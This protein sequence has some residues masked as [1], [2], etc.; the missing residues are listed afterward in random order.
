MPSLPLASLCQAHLHCQARV[1][2]L[3]I[4]KFIILACA[5]HECIVE[6]ME[7]RLLILSRSP[8]MAECLCEV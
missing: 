6:V 7:L 4:T 2:M 1:V 3:L 8:P 5:G